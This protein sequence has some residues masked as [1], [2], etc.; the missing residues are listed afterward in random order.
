MPRLRSAP[1]MAPGSRRSPVTRS[2]AAEEGF[3]EGEFWV[4][5]RA[6]ALLIGGIV[7]LGWLLN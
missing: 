7:A 2:S 4:V 6:V 5:A 3:I 1:L